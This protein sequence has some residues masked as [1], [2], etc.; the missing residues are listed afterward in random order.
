M[1]I[2]SQDEQARTLTE[3][4]AVLPKSKPRVHIDP[5]LDQCPVCDELRA[6]NARLAAEVER[7]SVESSDFE[8]QLY[9][10]RIERDNEQEATMLARGAL[11]AKR[12]ARERAERDARRWRWTRPHLSISSEGLLSITRNGVRINAVPQDEYKDGDRMDAAIDAA[13]EQAVDAAI[14]AAL[15]EQGKTHELPTPDV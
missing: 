12:E 4:I 10:M 8:R 13:I 14:A 15:T 2:N 1:N 5:V 6:E 11:T 3:E 9:A 7:L